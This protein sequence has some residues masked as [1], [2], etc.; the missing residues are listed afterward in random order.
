LENHLKNN[1]EKT[2]TTIFMAPTLKI[3]KELLKENGFINA[4]IVD[5]SAKKK[6]EDCIFLLFRPKYFSRF[7]KFVNDE[8]NRTRSLIDD[9]D[10]ANGFVVLVYRLN[11]KFANDF[12][13]IKQSKYSKTSKSFQ[14]M[15]P[16]TVE[17]ERDNEKV[18]EKSLQY[19]VFNKTSEL[20]DY[21]KKNFFV[22]YREGDEIWHE[23]EEDKESLK[24]SV[25]KNIFFD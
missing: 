15:F 3:E 18:E 24:D 20:K 23:F 21:W 17:I 2:I 22:T 7:R 25:L 8:Y 19:R 16:E 4:F 10:Y 5:K 1:M 9:Y 6:Y 11:S 12:E 14:I 13:L